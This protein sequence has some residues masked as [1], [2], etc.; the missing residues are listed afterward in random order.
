M[1]APTCFGITLPSW[2]SV[3]SAVC[4]MRSWGAVDRILWIGVLC[5]VTWCVAIWDLLNLLVFHAY[6][7]EMHGS[8][9]KIPSKNLV[10]QRCAEGFS[11]GVKGF[12]S[13]GLLYRVSFLVSEK[14]IGRGLPGHGVVCRVMVSSGPQ[15]GLLWVRQL[16]PSAV[17]P[18]LCT[19]C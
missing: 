12:K 1:V 10:R 15:H 6:I 3:P 19:S 14:L 4:E 2:G 13:S 18:F 8:M 11:S 5:L 16:P 7:N 17:R 9:S